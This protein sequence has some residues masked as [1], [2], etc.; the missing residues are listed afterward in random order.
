MVYEE[1][2]MWKSA[3]A[4]MAIF[5]TWIAAWSMLVYFVPINI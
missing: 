2:S 1:E 4:D 3:W 5:I